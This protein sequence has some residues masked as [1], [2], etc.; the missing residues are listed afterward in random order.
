MLMHLTLQRIDE[1]GKFTEPL[2]EA[3]GEPAD[4]CQALDKFLLNAQAGD[5]F[6]LTI[7]VPRA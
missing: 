6:D 5:A 7:E 4:I 2:L 3:S 1:F